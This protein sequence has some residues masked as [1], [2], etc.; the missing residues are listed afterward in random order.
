M[1]KA[2]SIFSPLTVQDGNKDTFTALKSTKANA[3]EYQDI[4]KK[5]DRKFFQVQKAIKFLG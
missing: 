5:L 3:K 1:D 2:L 4:R